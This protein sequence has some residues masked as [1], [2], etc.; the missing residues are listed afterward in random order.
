LPNATRHD[1]SDQLGDHCRI[2]N[3]SRWDIGLFDIDVWWE[4][5]SLITIM[6]LG[7]WLEMRAIPQARGAL[8]VLA[9]LLPSTAERVKGAD[10]ETVPLSELR[11]G[12]IVLVRPGA[13]LPADGVVVEGTAELTSP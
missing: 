6:L 7:H 13:R 8:N 9:A 11:V 5:T 3:F 2:W 12:D 1:D 4:L 10:A